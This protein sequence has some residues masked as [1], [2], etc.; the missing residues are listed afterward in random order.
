MAKTE[1]DMA[2]LRVTAVMALV[3]IVVAIIGVLLHK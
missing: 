3:L 2:D 1:I